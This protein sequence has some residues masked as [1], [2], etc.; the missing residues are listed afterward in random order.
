[1]A[2]I[3][4]KSAAYDLS[5][6]STCSVCDAVIILMLR[7]AQSSRENHSRKNCYMYVHGI[8]WNLIIFKGNFFGT[9]CFSLCREVVLFQRWSV[10]TRVCPLL[11]GLSSFGV[12]FIGG[13]TVYYTVRNHYKW[14]F[15]YLFLL[16]KFQVHSLALSYKCVS[17]L[18]SSRY[19]A[20]HLLRSGSRT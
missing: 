5:S 15:P 18:S 8:Q 13:F 4:P 1:M 7:A 14:I 2:N 12:S 3:T 17:I 20:L 6:V 16:E 11:G 10:Y 9:S 19:K